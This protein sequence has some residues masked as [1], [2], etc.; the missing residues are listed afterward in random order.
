M[1]FINIIKDFLI[2]IKNLISKIGLK[3]IIGTLEKN[4]ILNKV[5]NFIVNHFFIISFLIIILLNIYTIFM[6]DIYYYEYL[7]GL[8]EGLK[9]K[10]GENITGV[11][12][13]ITIIKII[14]ISV[15]FFLGYIISFITYKKLYL[16]INKEETEQL[17]K[18][19]KRFI[20]FFFYFIVFVFVVIVFFLIYN[21]YIYFREKLILKRVAY[22]DKKKIKTISELRRLKKIENIDDVKE[23]FLLMYEDII[24]YIKNFNRS[25]ILIIVNFFLRK[26]Y[27]Q[28]KLD[29]AQY[30]VI[31][32]IIYMIISI[33]LYLILL[34]FYY[35]YIQFFSKTEKINNIIKLFFYITLIILLITILINIYIII[36]YIYKVSN[37]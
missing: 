1:L 28:I 37:N 20:N 27:D 17:K 13:I 32:M 11:K 36:K 33:L 34:I 5:L 16:E 26:I 15:I 35:Y 21:C 3:N 23:V 22:M 31:L 10:T 29:V 18:N 24:I 9:L 30:G 25:E 19:K 6:F 14:E 8:I 12:I 4:K 2:K 7:K